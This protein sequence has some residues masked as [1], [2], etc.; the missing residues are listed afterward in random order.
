MVFLISAIT[1]ILGQ[2]IF[3]HLL[4]MQG[5]LSVV[6]ELVGGLIFIY[7]MLRNSK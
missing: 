5:V 6:I 1:L 7:L 2:A 3:E 4:G